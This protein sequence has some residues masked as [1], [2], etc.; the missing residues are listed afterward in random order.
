MLSNILFSRRP[1]SFLPVRCE[2]L[3]PSLSVWW[4]LY[5]SPQESRKP[6]LSDSRKSDSTSKLDFT[7]CKTTIFVFALAPIPFIFSWLN[8]VKTIFP[9]FFFFLL[10]KQMCSSNTNGEMQLFDILHGSFYTLFWVYMDSLDYNKI[11]C[12]CSDID[13]RLSSFWP[14]RFKDFGRFDEDF[15]DVSLAL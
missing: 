11:L 8:E 10:Q 6:C 5:N 4:R 9:S 7:W 14:L 1:R 15:P 2:T 3:P 12:S 13:W